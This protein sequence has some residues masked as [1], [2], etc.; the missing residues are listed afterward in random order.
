MSQDRWICHA[1]PFKK[2]GELCGTVNK[3][4]DVYCVGCGCSWSQSAERRRTDRG[5]T[6]NEGG[7]SLDVPP[8][9]R[10]TP[11]TDRRGPKR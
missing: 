1:R 9:K 5:L 3:A 11:T 4:A 7:E 8:E 6:H 2:Q 10:I